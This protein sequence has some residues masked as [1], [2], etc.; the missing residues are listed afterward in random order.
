MLIEV[1]VGIIRVYEGT[2]S[3]VLEVKCLDQG[4]NYPFF[5]LSLLK[6]LSNYNSLTF[7]RGGSLLD[8]CYCDSTLKWITQ[9]H[10]P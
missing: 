10:I 2:D 3:P 4:M 5:N 9:F 1:S 8:C 7:F 6:I